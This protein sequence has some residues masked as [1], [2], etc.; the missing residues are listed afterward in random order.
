LVFCV[1]LDDSEWSEVVPVLTPKQKRTFN[2]RLETFRATKRHQFKSRGNVKDL[3][4]VT[5]PVDNAGCPPDYNA[6]DVSM[7]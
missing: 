5:S 6:T 2:K 3:F 4:N 7:N 1:V